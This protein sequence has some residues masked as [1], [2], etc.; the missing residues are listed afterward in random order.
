MLQALFRLS[1]CLTGRHAASTS[2]VRQRPSLTQGST[3]FL[4]C[5]RKLQAPHVRY[6]QCTNYT[7][8]VRF[9]CRKYGIMK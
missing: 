3:C 8:H 4:D 7:V 1:F 2:L 6:I 9:P 5:I